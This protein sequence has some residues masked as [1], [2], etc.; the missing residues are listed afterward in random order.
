MER[1]R[2]LAATLGLVALVV[3][4]LVLV[5]SALRFTGRSSLAD[6]STP[7]TVQT[8]VA[9]TAAPIQADNA[10]SSASGASPTTSPTTVLAPIVRAVPLMVVITA[11]DGS[12]AWRATTGSC[13]ST[14]ATL[15]LTSTGGRTWQ[16]VKSPY[17]V[18]MRVQPTDATRAFVAGADPNCVMGVRSTTDTGTTWTG[19]GPGSLS[20]TLTRDAKDPTKVR[21]P[22]GRTVAPCGTLVVI[23]VARSS[24]NAA[25]ALC[26]D[27]T[28]HTSGDDGRTWP[29]TG[30]VSGALAMDSKVV[31]GTVTAFVVGPADGCAGLRLKSVVNDVVADLGCAEIGPTLTPGTVALSV[32]SPDTGWLLAGEQTWRSTDGL[33]TWARA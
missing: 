6:A 26:A 2:R 32:P 25:Q 30:Q 15:S 5:F 3:V 14:S 20:E 13:G 19:T 24:A 4:D 29:Q 11:V 27:G 31:G 1:R 8:D 21:A 18:L 10:T 23:D 28:L 9:A 12:T 17:P 7:A 22:G 33:K 16:N